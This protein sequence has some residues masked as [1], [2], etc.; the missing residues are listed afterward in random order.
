[1]NK[2][3]TNIKVFKETN[4]DVNYKH[5]VVCNGCNEK[6]TA[7]LV[8]ED[9][10][11]KT[12]PILVGIRKFCDECN[13]EKRKLQSNKSNKA[14]KNRKC[15]ECGND[16]PKGR[17]FCSDTCFKISKK[18]K[19]RAEN[20]FRPLINGLSKV[21][22]IKYYNDL[23]SKVSSYKELNGI[24]TMKHKRS[25]TWVAKYCKPKWILSASERMYEVQK[26][27]VERNKQKLIEINRLPYIK[28]IIAEYYDKGGSLNVECECTN[29]H[30]L[31]KPATDLLKH[32]E[33]PTCKLIELRNDKKNDKELE[34]ETNRIQRE[35]GKLNK[36]L[37]RVK[38]VSDFINSG[39]YKKYSS[40]KH[41]P[42][43][44]EYTWLRNGFDKEYLTNELKERIDT[45]NYFEYMTAST[46]PYPTKQ[47]YKWC[48]KCR[49]EQ[50]SDYIR[51]N[52][53]IG[54]SKIYRKEN[55]YEKY[56]IQLKVNYHKNPIAKL[57]TLVRVYILSALKGKPKSY[58]TKDILGMEWDEFRNYIENQF[59]PWMNWD[60]HGHGRGKWVLQHI[61]PKS[62][63]E[64]EDDVYRL[65]YYKNLMPM[66]FSDN[67]GLGDRILK[68][69]LNEWHYDNCTDFLDK[70]EDRIIE[71]MD[72][73]NGY[74]VPNEPNTL[75]NPFW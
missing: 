19:R 42:I 22:E 3:I 20:I 9:G 14:R 64:N 28:K 50:H 62:F 35:K 25:Y 73:I 21:N 49:I 57:Q 33:C 41:S 12:H 74:N 58:R 36:S 34:L 45:I 59:E 43:S 32:M 38:L 54:C 75:Y 27:K 44:S 52:I 56:K 68:Y 31:K 10:S 55:Y 1:M 37:D 30:M 69:Q 23:I 46:C 40:W 63:A 71:S 11:L 8:T 39:E 29:G 66:N 51:R 2:S 24:D 6:L 4:V 65:N 61:I 7:S 67:G 72:E 60:N 16:N 13:C 18:R 15:K 48:R 47:N 70:Y 26:E 17:S 5:Y 53:C